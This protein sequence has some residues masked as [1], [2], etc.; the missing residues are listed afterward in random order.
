MRLVLEEQEAK[1]NAICFYH[2]KKYSYLSSENEYTASF[3]INDYDKAVQMQIQSIRPK[4][5]KDTFNAYSDYLKKDFAIS[6]IDE[7]KNC[8]WDYTSM[9]DH[10]TQLNEA[11]QKSRFGTLILFNTQEGLKKALQLKPVHDAITQGRL[12]IPCNINQLYMPYNLLMGA[13][14]LDNTILDKYTNIYLI[15][16]FALPASGNTIRYFDEDMQKSYRLRARQYFMERPEL[17]KNYQYIKKYIEQGTLAS[18]ESIDKLCRV[19][20]ISM[21]KTVFMTNVFF[22]LGLID[23]INRDK[24]QFKTDSNEKKDLKDS[25]T[26]MS[27]LNIIN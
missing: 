1:C 26:Y 7:I 10:L 14:A 6:F 9:A 22:E 19:L 2:V 24:I 5:T 20:N 4:I 21:E 3:A 12:T 27:F 18:D 23:C 17:L 8:V 15:G 25:G 11:L 16:A 13:G